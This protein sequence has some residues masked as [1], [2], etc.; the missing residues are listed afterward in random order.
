[1]AVNFFIAGAAI[2]TGVMLAWL[3]P[4]GMRAA[5]RF[6]HGPEKQIRGV[7]VHTEDPINDRIEI[8]FSND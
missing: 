8:F 5:R 6:W 3:V 2:F 1:M 4:A 7:L